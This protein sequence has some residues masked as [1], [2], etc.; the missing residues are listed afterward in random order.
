MALLVPA[1]VKDNVAGL[2]GAPCWLINKAMSLV[3]FDVGDEYA[4]EGLVE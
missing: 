3:L 4:D 1:H 2:D